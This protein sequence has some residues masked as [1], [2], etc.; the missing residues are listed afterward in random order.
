MEKVYEGKSFLQNMDNVVFHAKTSNFLSHHYF[1]MQ[2]TPLNAKYNVF[3]DVI[4]KIL[5]MDAALFNLFFDIMFV[6]FY[7]CLTEHLCDPNQCK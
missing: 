1:R 6:T 3:Y 4:I 7:F 2:A 5:T